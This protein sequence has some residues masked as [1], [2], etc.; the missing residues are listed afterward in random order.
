MTVLIEPVRLAI[1]DEPAIG[2]FDAGQTCPSVRH[3]IYSPAGRF[4]GSAATRGRANRSGRPVQVPLC[5][6]RT[7]SRVWLTTLTSPTRTRA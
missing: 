1:D 5:I 6:P 2:E 7:D 3:R 4:A